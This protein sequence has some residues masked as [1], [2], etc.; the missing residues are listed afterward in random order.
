MK[1]GVGGKREGESEEWEIAS[2][3]EGAQEPELERIHGRRKANSTPHPDR[4]RRQSLVGLMTVAIGISRE[5][6]GCHTIY[7]GATRGGSAW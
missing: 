5:P 2:S 7:I 4:F 6:Q 1:A 3:G